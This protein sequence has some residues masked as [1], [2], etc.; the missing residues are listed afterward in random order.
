MKRRTFASTGGK[1]ETSK[2]VNFQ[3]EQGKVIGCG[4]EFANMQ[5]K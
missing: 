5:R 3:V 2:V 1:K 4:W